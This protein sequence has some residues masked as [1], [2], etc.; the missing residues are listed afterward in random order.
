MRTSEA[1]DKYVVQLRGDGRSVHTVKQAKRFVRKFAETA[2]DPQVGEV[3]PED[4]STFLASDAVTRRSD[5]G[6]RKA[7][8]ANAM[9]SVLRAFFAFLHAAGFA[10]TNPARL[11]RRARCSPPKPRALRDADVERL[12][13]ALDTATTAA[14]RRDRVMFRLMLGVGLRVGSVVALDVGDVDQ[15]DASITVRTMKNGDTDTVFPSPDLMAMLA[16]HIAGRKTGPLFPQANG[17][18]IGPR[19]VA[20]RL[21]M[22]TRRAEIEGKVGPHRLRHS[23]AIAAYERTRD[24]LL[25]GR[26]LGHKSIGSTMVY[27]RPS[28]QRVRAAMA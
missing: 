26:L 1:L 17:G 5:G 13:V 3:R 14:E 9:R 23:F 20:R 15:A 4:I 25:V 7:N 12:L 18:R 28:D 10:P 24:V 22:W 21:G 11:V 8:S 6:P 16:T 19:Q 27:A 2:G